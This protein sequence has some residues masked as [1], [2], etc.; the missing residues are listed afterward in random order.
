MKKIFNFIWDN[1]K[2]ILSFNRLAS[3]KVIAICDDQILVK[4]INSNRLGFFFF[5]DEDV[6]PSIVLDNYYDVE[7]GYCNFDYDYQAC[8]N[9]EFVAELICFV[10]GKWWA[11]IYEGDEL[12]SYSL[13]YGVAAS[14]KN[15][16][17]DSV[18]V[19]QGSYC[20]I[21]TFFV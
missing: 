20:K 13:V 6:R 8:V 12:I 15:R 21:P 14:A 3:I 2:D 11:K 5:A 18:K 16:K 9:G 4:D 17:I 1:I 7:F 19:S 10:D